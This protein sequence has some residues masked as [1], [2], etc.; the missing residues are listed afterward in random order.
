[1][2]IQST[3]QPGTFQII[4]HY[5][6]GQQQ[7]FE[8]ESPPVDNVNTTAQDVRSSLRRFLQEGWWTI[9]TPNQTYFINPANV[10]N[11]ELRPAANMLEG[12]GVLHA[13]RA[14]EILR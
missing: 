1:M 13:V 9:H 14:S 12:E 2:Q 7:V 11:L 4:V 3:T 8:I 5:V 10:L 6:N